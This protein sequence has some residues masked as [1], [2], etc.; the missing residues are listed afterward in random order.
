VCGAMPGM[1]LE[2]LRHLVDEE[3]QENT[4]GLGGI[5]RAFEGVLRGGRFAGRVAC[6]RRQQE[7]PTGTGVTTGAEPSRTGASARSVAWGSC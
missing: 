4:I 1:P 3:R 7:C 5:K 2:Q 6:D